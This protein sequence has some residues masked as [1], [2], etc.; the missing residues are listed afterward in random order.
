MNTE[1]II[2][3]CIVI[4]IIIIAIYTSNSI[5]IPF[6]ITIL[7]L[8]GIGFIYH[9]RRKKS[10]MAEKSI[11]N[12]ESRKYIK[13]RPIKQD[14]NKHNHGSKSFT[15]NV[16]EHSNTTL[17]NWIDL[18]ELLFTQSYPHIVPKSFKISKNRIN[19]SSIDILYHTRL[20]TEWIFEESNRR[21]SDTISNESNRR[22]Y[23]LITSLDQLNEI[24]KKYIKEHPRDKDGNAILYQKISNVQES[25]SFV[26]TITV[27]NRTISSE[28]SSN[29]P[30]PDKVSD[31]MK[32]I[33]IIVDTLTPIHNNIIKQYKIIMIKLNDMLHSEDNVN[34]Q[35]YTE[36]LIVDWIP[37][38]N[39]TTSYGVKISN[40]FKVPIQTIPAPNNRPTYTFDVER[41]NQRDF[42][43]YT[44][45]N[46]WRRIDINT[47][48][49]IGQ[50]VDLHFYLSA[51]SSYNAAIKNT[52]ARVQGRLDVVALSNKAKLHQLI[53]NTPK[54]LTYIPESIIIHHQKN[55]PNNKDVKVIPTTTEPWIWRPEFGCSGWGIE[56]VTSKAELD[57]VIDKYEY[58]EKKYRFVLSRYITNPKLIKNPENGLLYKFHIRLWA[59]VS[60]DKYDVMRF[61]LVNTGNLITSNAPY[62]NSDYNN[63]KIHDTHQGKSLQ[64]GEGSFPQ[65]FPGTDDEKSKLLIDI[66]V[67]FKDVFEA[68]SNKVE[69][70]DKCES[71][72]QIFGIDMMVTDE[73]KPVLIEINNQPG[74]PG[75]HK[76]HPEFVTRLSKEFYSGMWDTVINPLVT[77][78]RMVENHKYITLLTTIKP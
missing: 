6:G 5:V 37:I 77:G 47:V 59:I 76:Y 22:G 16:I 65:D 32:S 24:L 7:A 62:I 4:I 57:A 8:L 51:N 36:Y 72:F 45:K 68:I 55:D 64:I 43:A 23:I 71:G 2:A 61:G 14:Y 26:Y 75:Y 1:Y 25:L 78:V 46:K 33:A 50:P 74:L 56:V 29:K 31:I 10:G 60:I 40:E 15:R 49:K 67:M 48:N 21:S 19:Y 69:K 17:D 39:H 41:L 34:Y 44:I 30:I 11:R 42:L 18:F 54:L 38:I 27:L 66:R 53:I 52:P 20:G 9:I 73:N 3:I 13:F 70:M 63:K 28:L 58:F 35:N 12:T